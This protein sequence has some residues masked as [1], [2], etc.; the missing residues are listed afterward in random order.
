MLHPMSS[1]V[2]AISSRCDAPSSV[3][4][5]IHAYLVLV[6]VLVLGTVQ[7]SIVHQGFCTR[8]RKDA[9][10]G[11]SFVTLDDRKHEEIDASAAAE[12]HAGEN[13]LIAEVSQGNGGWGL[14]LRIEDENGGKLQLKSDGD[15]RKAC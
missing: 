2:L 1:N 3:V 13:T 4:P 11:S 5:Q 10:S 7:R 12:P 8:A 15:R 9:A 14:C 6:I